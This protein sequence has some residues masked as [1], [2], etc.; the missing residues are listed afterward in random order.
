MSR[1]IRL[2]LA[3]GIACLAAAS[4]DADEAPPAPDKSGFSLFDPTPAEAMRTFSPDRPDKSTSPLTIDAGHAQL[5]MDLLGT[6]YTHGGGASMQQFF[7]ADPVL[8]LGVTNNADVE[9]ELGGYQSIR[10]TDRATGRSQHL[11]GFGDVTIRTKINLVGNDGGD[12]AAAIV[13]TFKLPTATGGVG[14]GAAEFGVLAP[15]QLALPLDLTALFVTEIDQLKN[16][17]NTGRHASFTNL[18][19]IS[20]PITPELTAEVEIWSQV[21]AQHEPSQYSLDLA[22]AYALGPNTQLDAALYVGL[23]AQTPALV[24]YIGMAQRF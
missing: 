19:N 2:F 11:S 1:L 13:P 4:A 20:H 15:V 14:N 16:A 17:V 8:K 6:L 18:L 23:N 21:Q 22:A 24:G 10:V 7:S 3:C 9:V 12:F 5:E